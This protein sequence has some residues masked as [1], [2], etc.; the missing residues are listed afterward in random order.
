MLCDDCGKR[1]ATVFLKEIFSG[2][3]VEHH[4][5]SECAHKRGLIEEKKMAPLEMLQNLL[6]DR[7]AGDEQIICG[8]CYSSLADFKRLG[9]FGCVHCVETFAP[10]IRHLV[11]EIHNSEHHIGRRPAVTTADG[12]EV[13]RLREE[14][15]H[16]LEKEAYEEA[17][18]IRDRLKALGVSNAD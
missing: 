9:R 14:L 4:L 2:K 16:A 13:M 17:A 3:I 5:C 15:K 1:P 12:F 7:D 11:Q 18:K 6:R 8:S 10:H